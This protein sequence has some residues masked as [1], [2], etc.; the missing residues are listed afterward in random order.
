ME[1]RKMINLLLLLFLVGCNA[2]SKQ[3]TDRW[4]E[5]Q[6]YSESVLAIPS[7]LLTDAQRRFI[8]T[9][10]LILMH[11]MD[12]KDD[13]LIFNVDTAIFERNNISLKYI[14][15]LKENVAIQDRNLKSIIKETEEQGGKI[16]Y[17]E[18][19]E[20]L[21]KAKEQLN[22]RSQQEPSL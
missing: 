4:R 7:S 21:D 5:P 17:R 12:V 20:S 9:I 13:K 3:V 22:S 15:I 19:K 18:I 8:D 16:T 1:R 14:N 2:N 10:N 11:G 6:E